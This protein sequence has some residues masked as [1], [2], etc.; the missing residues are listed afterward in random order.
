V[1]FIRNSWLILSKHLDISASRIQLGAVFLSRWLLAYAT[2]SWVDLCFRNPNEFCLNLP[3]PQDL[4]PCG[5]P[6]APLDPSWSESPV[7]VC[8]WTRAWGSP[9]FVAVGLC[10]FVDSEQFLRV[11][12]QH[13]DTVLHPLPTDFVKKKHSSSFPSFITYHLSYSQDSGCK[14]KN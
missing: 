7:S 14:A 13:L 8:L 2:A 6:L 4:P 3:P 1:C 5:K 12:L 11:V 10:T 9:P